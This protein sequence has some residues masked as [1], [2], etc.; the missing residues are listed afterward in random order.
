MKAKVALLSAVLAALLSM[1]GTLRAQGTAQITGTVKDA[2]GAVMPG[3]KVTLNSQLTGMTREVTTGSSGDYVFALLPVGVYTVTAEKQGFQLAKRTDIPLNV[4]AVMRVDL[5]L[6]VGAVTQS[7]EVKSSAVALETESS[8][9]TQLMGQ[10]QVNE[11]PLNGRNFMSFLLLGAGAVTV[12][13]EQGSMRQG[14]G[15]AI[16]INGARPT[17]L[18]YMLDG[19]VN[20][21]TA[22]NTPSVILSQ[23]AIQEFKEQTATYSAEYGFSA[24]QINIISKSGGNALHGSV[25]EFLRNNKFDARNTFSATKPVLRQNQ[26]GYVASGPVYIP[27]VYDGR[28]KTFWLANYE[29]WRIRR[30]N[31]QTG[32]VPPPEWLTGDFSASGLPAFGT[33]ACTTQL[34]KDYPCM[35]ID[36]ETGLP[37]ALNQIP[38]TRNSRLAKETLALKMVPAPNMTLTGGV[39]YKTL[40]NLPQTLNQQ[41]YKGDQELGRWGRVSGRYT[42]SHFQSSTLGTISRPYG[43][44]HFVEDETAWM[45]SHTVTLGPTNVNNARFGRLESTANQCATSVDQSVVDSLG[46]TGVFQGIDDCSRSY[47][48]GL[49]LPPYSG[50]G[51]PV[52]DTTLSNIPM[53]EGADSF[54]MVRGKHTL[55]MGGDGRQWVQ[56]RNL[57]ADYLGTPGFRSDLILNNG[58]NGVN[59]CATPYCGTGNSVADFLLG[60]Y[61][62]TGIYQPGPFSKPGVAGNTNRYHFQYFATYLQDD[63]KVGPR[64]T[65]NL[66]L[67]YDFRTVPFEP[68]NKMGW[69]DMSNPDGGLCIADPGL[70]TEGIAPAGSMYRYCGRRNPADASKKV[71]AP[72]FG[73]AY[74][75]FGEKT[76][77]RGGY[78]VFFDSAEGREIDDSGDI[79][80]YSVRSNILPTTQPVASAPKL[81]DQLY[82]AYSTVSPVAPEKLTFIAVI[83]S[84]RPRNPYVQQWSFSI[85]RELARNTTLEV[86][87]I[88][89]R[90]IHLLTRTNIAR[91]YRVSNPEFCSATDAGGAYIN[92]NNGDCPIVTRR[93]YPNFTGFYINSEWWGDASYN[94]ANVKLER[95][96]STMSF[97]AVY[98]WAKSLDNKSAAAGIGGAGIGW[99]GFMDDHNPGLDRGRSDFDVDHRFV[100]NFV[101]ELPFGRGRHYLGSVNK[102]VDSVLGGWQVTGIGVGA[103][104]E[105]RGDL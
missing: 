48:G 91:A 15:D 70:L 46:L 10:R 84:E 47:P 4:A 78:G 102:V 75:P 5:E 17:S 51:G 57:N 13:G 1:A 97:Q 94:S 90:G 96:T 87:Y 3:V 67:R 28:N 83:I 71:F 12:G 63:W 25:F 45:F 74:R 69:L 66:G 49:G 64:L 59:G 99:D 6:Q 101:Y 38:S 89:N 39:N 22:L 82:P 86:N 55:A 88:G 32:Y 65:L 37:F 58:G 85:Q 53:W 26:F 77:I 21:D 9:V 7:I 92:L 61:H 62:D 36:P 104:V 80:P 103:I 73:F 27:G 16:S 54:T 93:P 79:Y 52:N 41:T 44:N 68:D 76:V 29:G 42:R 11:L 98:T 105:P 43:D 19:M 60:Y 2:T 34:A 20:T 30:G 8:A 14:K 23:D 100:T 18:N 35:P 50:I 81:T 56:N 33:A 24:N 72:R 95:R 40:V 31:I